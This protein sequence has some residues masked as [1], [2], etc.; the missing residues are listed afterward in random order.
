M[1]LSKTIKAKTIDF[2]YMYFLYIALSNINLVMIMLFYFPSKVTIETCHY[3]IN[4]FYHCL[5]ATNVIGNF[6]N[7]RNFFRLAMKNNL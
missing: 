7:F 3:F 6:K 4:F 5:G 1:Y 2:E